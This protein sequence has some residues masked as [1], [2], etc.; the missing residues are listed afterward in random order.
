MSPPHASVSRRQLQRELRNEPDE[1]EPGEQ[2]PPRPRRRGDCCV[3]VG[4][5]P[6][7]YAS[8]RYNLWAEVSE[9]GSL[10]Y[11][12]PGQELEELEH[13]C[14]L[15]LAQR[16]PPSERD[17]ACNMTLE[18]IGQVLGCTRERVR[19]IETQALEK[20]AA[21]FARSDSRTA[22]WRRASESSATPSWP[23]LPRGAARSRASC[24][25]TR[26]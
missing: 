26:T 5:R 21:H 15:D 24:S 12:H 17:D 19:Q 20:L 14:A 11:L 16:P 25:T 23:G 22:T 8:C 3:G 13:T 10:V 6:C 4:I 1:L 9:A 7:P 2:L 18:Q